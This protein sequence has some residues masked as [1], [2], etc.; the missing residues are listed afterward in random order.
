MASALLRGVR[1]SCRLSRRV[2]HSGNALS[3]NDAV[4]SNFTNRNPRNLEQMLLAHK[5]GGFELDKPSCSYW[6]KLVFESSGQS[7]SGSVVH[8][9]G[10]VV[11]QVSSSE[12]GIRKQLVSAT[13]R[14]AA[15]AV[16]SV[17]ARR[18][19]EAGLLCVQAPTGDQEGP[20][21]RLQAFLDGM[22]EGGVLLTES[23]SPH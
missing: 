11:L 6:H 17:L 14:S 19:L 22:K 5:H 23:W 21:L 8:V 18:C 4:S 1:G 10:Q 13:D 7:L 3:E 15:A 2:L 20:S 9:D 16:A 12:W